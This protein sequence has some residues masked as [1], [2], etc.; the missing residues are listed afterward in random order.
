[1]NNLLP[2]LR[3]NS[4]NEN[5]LIHIV[6]IIVILVALALG[7]YLVQTRTNINPFAQSVSGP[8][9]GP[10]GDS[11][12]DSFTDSQ[13]FFMGTNPNVACPT[14]SIDN[15]WPVDVNNDKSIN[16]GDVST[17]VPYINGSKPY[18]KRYDLNQDAVISQGDVSVIQ[19]NFLKTCEA[20][21]KTAVIRISPKTTAKLG[22]EVEVSVFVSAYTDPVNLVSAQINYPSD[23]LDVVK[24]VT[25]SSGN[26]AEGFNTLYEKY[27]GNGQISIIK[28]STNGLTTGGPNS[29]VTFARITFKTKA[30]GV[31]NITLNKTTSEILRVKDGANVLNPINDSA[32]EGSISVYPQPTPTPA[33][34]PKPFPS[35]GCM[36]STQCKTDQDCRRMA[37]YPGN[38]MDQ[39]IACAQVITKACYTLIENNTAPQEI[40]ADFSNP[41]VV[42]PGWHKPGEVRPTPTP[43]AC[44]PRPIIGK[45]TVMTAQG[46]KVTLTPG[47]NGNTSTNPIRSISFTSFDNASV[48][49][50][51]KFYTQPV[52]HQISN[53]GGTQDITFFVNQV[54]LNKASTVQMKVNDTC[55]PYDLFFGGGTQAGWP[56]TIPP[57]QTPNPTTQATASAS[58]APTIACTITKAQ[59]VG[60]NGIVPSNTTAKLLV[61]A[62]GNCIS[63]RIIF[64]IWEDDGLLGADP[65]LTNPQ[66]VFLI[67]N[68]QPNQYYGTTTWRTEF[69]EDGPFGS[70]Y[71]PEF[72]FEATI[73][74][75]KNR[76]RSTNQLLVARE[77]GAPSPI[78]GDTNKDQ[79]VNLKDISW[80]LTFWDKK[81]NDEALDIDGNDNIVNNFDMTKLKGILLQRGILRPIP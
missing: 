3:K 72:S 18:N 9:S 12:K 56:T 49:I 1:M 32:Y 45:T 29:G 36:T 42:P 64:N 25:D 62:N 30:Y 74:G 14:S 7:V 5:G 47:T 16:G 60:N 4:L 77:I 69:Q 23:K 6:I 61:E 48:T 19:A 46:L 68:G 40:C 67:S 71:P 41:C 21:E 13:E 15:A 54:A 37:P 78:E 24:V 79:Q 39:N 76:L 11:D 43:T 63:K 75:E 57:Q 17:L 80:M 73:D 2:N 50:D 44:L 58:I 35:D 66:E 34:N 51:G 53:S 33:V 59:W 70:S 27:V 55:G 20:I 26:T 52:T 81:V 38:C 31:S 65:V 22:D 28:G 8:I 10:L